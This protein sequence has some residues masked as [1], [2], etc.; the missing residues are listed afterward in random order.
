[1][2]SVDYGEG[3]SPKQLLDTINAIYE[4]AL[5]PDHYE[6]FAEQWDTYI[7]Q[8]DPELDDGIDLQVH[9]EKALT[10]LDRLH[11]VF[12]DEPDAETLVESEVGPAAIIDA[13]GGLIASNSGWRDFLPEPV[14]KLWELCAEPEDSEKLKS[15]VMSLHE[16]AEPRTGFLQIELPDGSVTGV[17]VR[18]LFSPSETAE[19]RY[20]VRITRTLWSDDVG[21]LIAS[22]FKLTEAELALLKRMTVGESFAAVADETGRS[23]ETLKTQSRSIYRKMLASNREDAVRTAL[24][25]HLVF[26]GRAPT[27]IAPVYGPD[28]GIV[29]TP[30]G[31]RVGWTQR[32]ASNGTPILFLHGMTV[33]H[34]MTKAFLDALVKL[35]ITAICVDRPGY[36]RSDPFRDWRQSVE[37]WAEM[38]PSILDA[39]DL[40]TVT[41]VTHTS[42]VL[43]GCAAATA[44]PDRINGVC[45]LAGGVP[46]NDLSMLADYPTQV[47][48][49]SRTARMSATA[50]RFFLGSSTVFYRS[51]S[52]RRRI[53]E[54]AYGH[55][56]SDM[57]AIASPEIRQLLIEGMDLI[58][59]SGFDGFVGDG[60]R[61]FGDWSEYVEKMQVPLHYVIG[62]EDP[63][64]PLIWAQSFAQ[65]YKHAQVTPIAGAG[66]LL[67]HTKSQVVAEFIGEFVRDTQR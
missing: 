65:K 44:H 60:L 32:G 39:F 26:A 40:K 49:M 25:F 37:R 55:S 51:E 54:R 24:Q 48:I 13:S 31:L 4:V 38:V 16:I 57:R 6:V 2:G 10:I 27:K 67:H 14:K 43:Y 64:C 33:G 42:G 46:I 8:V 63:V 22:E 36:G 18:R 21:T 3:P 29:T 61:I 58:A 34:S 50:L 53:I 30:E 52:G 15:V 45:A 12:L 11:T 56:P 23:S 62:E 66:Q 28:Q 17:A 59:D 5:T 9:F 19:S 1:M 20:L 41:I 47:R 35:N 7:A